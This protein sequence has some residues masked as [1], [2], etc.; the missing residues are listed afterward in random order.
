MQCAYTGDVEEIL[1]FKAFEGFKKQVACE[2]A[3]DWE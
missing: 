2:T 3:N 1:M